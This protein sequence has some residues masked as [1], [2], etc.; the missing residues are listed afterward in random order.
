MINTQ[1]RRILVVLVVFGLLVLLD[2]S[3]KLGWMQQV[4]LFFGMASALMGLMLSRRLENF[5]KKNSNKA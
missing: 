5:S 2:L 3:L 4:P 1:L